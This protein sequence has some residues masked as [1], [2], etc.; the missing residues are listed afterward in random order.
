VDV[1]ERPLSTFVAGDK[2]LRRRECWAWDQGASVDRESQRGTFRSVVCGHGCLVGHYTN[3]VNIK[4]VARPLAG[5]GGS[6]P[7]NPDV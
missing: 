3:L 4:R 2:R 6:S 5:I 7:A 1:V